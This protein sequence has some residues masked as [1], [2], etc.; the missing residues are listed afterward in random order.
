MTTATAA[1]IEL[2]RESKCLVGTLALVLGLAWLMG[3][4]KK[5]QTRFM[6]LVKDSAL[7]VSQNMNV[8]KSVLEA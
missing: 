1:H 2:T 6:L 8:Y 5:E 4:K 7:P 3:V